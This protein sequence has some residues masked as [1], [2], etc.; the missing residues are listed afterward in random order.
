MKTSLESSMPYR[1]RMPLINGM[2]NAHNSRIGLK[3]ALTMPVENA[4]TR[5]QFVSWRSAIMANKSSE[6]GIN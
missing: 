6:N 3:I 5:L 2:Q 4:I 1:L